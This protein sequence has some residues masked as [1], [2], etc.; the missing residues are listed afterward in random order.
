MEPHLDATAQA[1]LVRSGEVTPRELDGGRHRAD[2]GAQRRPQRG[3][4]PALRGGARRPIRPTARSRACRSS[5]RTSVCQVAGH[6]APRGHALPARPRSP[7]RRRLVA[8]LALPRSRASCSSARPTRRSWASCRPPS[9]TP[10]GRRATPGDTNHSTGR[11]E[12]RL[13]AAPWRRGWCRSGT[14]TTAAARSASRPPAAAWSGLKATRARV[15]M[16]PL[17]RLRRRP[18]PTDL[19]VSRSVRDSGG[20][21]RVRLRGGAARRALLRAAQAARRTPRRS[22][23]DPGKLRIGLMTTA[24][25]ALDAPAHPD[26]VAAAEAAARTLEAL[27]HIVEVAH[28]GALDDPNYV[29]AVP[30]A[31]DGRRGRRRWTSGACAPASRSRRTTWSR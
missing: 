28:P 13:G 24:P 7:R 26:C 5:S 22:G 9:P 15:S 30:G 19:V 11:V 16:A 10:T 23:A 27:G 17:G 8:H 1:D 2:R 12:R 21:A 31:L 18:G 4:P 29:A 25:A 6:S 3:H 14:P 20:G